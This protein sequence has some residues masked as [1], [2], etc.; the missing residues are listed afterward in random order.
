M[1][2]LSKLLI[3][4]ILIVSPLPARAGGAWIKEVGKGFAKVTVTQLTA[5]DIHD[6]DGALQPLPG[7]STQTVMLYGEFGMAKDVEAIVGIPAFKSNATSEYERVNGIGDVML[8]AKMKIQGGDWPVAAGV[9]VELPT[10]SS[11]LSGNAV[12]GSGAQ[13]NMPTGDGELNTWLFG[14]VSHSF[15][16]T[17]VYGTLEAG[18]NFRSI[19]V[20]EYTSKFDGG[21]LTN[22][23]YVQ[24]EVGYAPMEDLWLVG[25]FRRYAPAGTAQRGRFTFFGLGEGVQWNAYFLGASYKFDSGLGVS[26]DYSGAF[27]VRAIYAG[28]NFIF[29]LF[30]E[31]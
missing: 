30:Y 3:T 4:V 28:A 26:F 12:D 22:T 18:Y 25:R 31:W 9:L 5:Q 19:A 8:G 2:P 1:R 24:L 10:G 11:S 6:F 7:I 20:T 23:Y 27:D 17:Q 16:P 15:W 13:L 21:N 29:G 14:A